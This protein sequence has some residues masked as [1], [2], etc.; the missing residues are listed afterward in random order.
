MIEGYKTMKRYIFI[1]IYDIKIAL[2]NIKFKDPRK[3]TFLDKFNTKKYFKKNLVKEYFM[4]AE[5]YHIPRMSVREYH[6]FKNGII[7]KV[8][9]HY[10][11]LIVILTCIC[12]SIHVFYTIIQEILKSGVN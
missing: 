2:R 3:I 1:F 12:I 8:K 5:Y 7:N 9:I 4:R 6:Y 11:Y 10:L